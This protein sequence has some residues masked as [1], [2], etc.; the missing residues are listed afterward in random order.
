METIHKQLSKAWR[1]LWLQ[2]WVHLFGW[3]L[4]VALS[5]AF[6]ACLFPKFYFIPYRFEFWG[7]ASIAV[8][9]ILSAVIATAAAWWRRPSSIA[10]AVEIDRRFGLR[11][12]CSSSLS[13]NAV[14]RDTAIGQ[15]LLK[16]TVAKLERVDIRDQFPVKPGPHIV[17]VALPLAACLA[18][19]WVPDAELNVANALG[20]SANAPVVNI[21]NHTAPILKAIQKK[22]EE[23]ES[24]GDA[25]SAEQFKRIE[26]K[27]NSLQNSNEADR[28][29]IIA[30]INELKKELQQKKES[31]GSSEQLKKSLEGMKD[32]NA[33]PAEKMAK[34]L[35]EGEFDKAEQELEKMIEALK[36]DKL[37]PEQTQQLQ[38]QLEQM[39][40]AMEQA[41]AKQE[42]QKQQLEKELEKAEKEGDTQKIADLRKKLEN[43][44][45]AQAGQGKSMD[46]IQSQLAKA[47]QAM[48]NGDKQAAADALEEMQDEL[49]EL[50]ENQADSEEL[51]DMIEQFENA[52][53]ASKCKECNGTGCKECNQ[54]GKGQK[55]GKGKQ[56]GKGKGK[57]KSDSDEPGDGEGEGKGQGDRAESESD[58]KDYDAQVR[59][60]MRKG[61]TVN[62]GKADGKNRKGMTRE[63][64]RQAVLSSEPDSPDAIESI[65]LPKAQRDQLKEYFDSLRDN[66]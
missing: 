58:F 61:E 57:G 36:S 48:Q 44:E 56:G 15:A 31:L 53:S 50:A 8:A 54:T 22:R 60:E 38:K 2:S 12:R 51:E 43:L 52:K 9:A 1:R 59:E 41:K 35:Q 62:G 24:K 14:D 42:E 34:A 63:E 23:A 13:M 21:K 32:L 11:E 10:A 27:I 64:A 55:S 20:N 19:F 6:V 5:I 37:T 4:L 66:Q 65:Q 30:D 3:S 17:W 18:L 33:G 39:Q 49:S 45:N 7:G 47:Q 16:D 29:K 26:E 40:K 25:E 46:K 28:K